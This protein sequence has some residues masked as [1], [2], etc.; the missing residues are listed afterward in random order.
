M[1]EDHIKSEITLYLAGSL[2]ESRNR[3]IEAHAA[4]CEKCR[5][6]LAKAR[7][8]LSRIKREA[9]KKASPDPLPNLFLARQGK[10][11][12]ASRPP[13][14]FPWRVI[15]V[16]VAAGV[17]YK[18]LRHSSFATRGAI[19]SPAQADPAVPTSDVAVSSPSAVTAPQVE[20]AAVAAKKPEPPKEPTLIA[21]QQQWQGPD[22]SVKESRVVVIRNKDDWDKLRADM[23]NTLPEI[24]FA[25]HV[26]IGVFAGERPPGSTVSFGT[27]RERADDV[28]AP[29]RINVAEVQSSTGT[30]VVPEHPYALS[31]LPKLEKRIRLTQKEVSP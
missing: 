9:L 8:K 11:A 30:T 25:Q 1:P 2:T 13:M 4:A 3:Q 29:Y 27:I 16:L 18:I 10:E 15:V 21:V 5:N 7:S 19:N 31:L 17:G 26:L 22:S 14:N 24:D 20:A 12:G 28:Y 23:Q 6:A